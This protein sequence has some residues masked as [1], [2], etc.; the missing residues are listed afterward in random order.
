MSI[1][2]GHADGSM[3]WNTAWGQRVPTQP[4]PYLD[5]PRP[6]RAVPT[7]HDDTGPPGEPGEADDGWQGPLP[8]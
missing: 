5:Q 8:F 4:R 1:T 3:T 6:P 2:A 7:N